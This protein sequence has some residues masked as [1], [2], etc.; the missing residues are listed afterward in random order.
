MRLSL[1]K[2]ERPTDEE[3]VEQRR[4]EHPRS[5]REV[6]RFLFV[7]K[8]WVNFPSH[9]DLTLI[10]NTYVS[11]VYSITNPKKNT[12]GTRCTKLNKS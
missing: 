10:R 11:I 7:I 5:Q 1:L 9:L 12:R 8:Y 6:I 2:K 3:V 4:T